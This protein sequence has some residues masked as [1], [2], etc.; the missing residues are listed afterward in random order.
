MPRIGTEMR[1]PEK[2]LGGRGREPSP[3]GSGVISEWVNEALL[4]PSSFRCDQQTP[5]FLVF[6]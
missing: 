6:Y 1:A 4:S 5:G 2:T 3:V